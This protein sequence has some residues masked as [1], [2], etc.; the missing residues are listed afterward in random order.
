MD[1]RRLTC[2]DKFGQPVIIPKATVRCD[3]APA[4]GDGDRTARQF[5]REALLRGDAQVVFQHV[6]ESLPSWEPG[7]LRSFCAAIVAEAG[8]G[9]AMDDGH[10]GSD[11]AARPPLRHRRQAQKLPACRS[12]TSALASLFETAP[13]LGESGRRALPAYRLGDAGL[14]AAPELGEETLVVNAE[15]FPPEGEECDA[16]L[17]RKAYELGWRRFICHGYRGQRFTGCGL[18]PDTDGVRIDVYG[19]SGDYLGSGIDGLRY[20]CTATGRTSSGR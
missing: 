18:G 16:F 20:A 13:R 9:T 10:R 5:V 6:T 2:A 15:G 17:V 8:N 14:L 7:A 3:L 1:R 12:S 4:N 19:S 11:A